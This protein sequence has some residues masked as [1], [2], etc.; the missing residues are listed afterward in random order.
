[1]AGRGPISAFARPVSRW[2][3]S[4]ST[5]AEGESDPLFL[6]QQ[7]KEEQIPSILVVIDKWGERPVSGLC[8]QHEYK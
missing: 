7:E 2:V 3:A 5:K 4:H 1:V 8:T 6:A